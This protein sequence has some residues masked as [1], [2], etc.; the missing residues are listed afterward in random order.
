[1]V[2]WDAMKAEMQ[3][4][5]DLAPIAVKKYRNGPQDELER[6]WKLDRKGFIREVIRRESAGE[7][8]ERA[9]CR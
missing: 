3:N 8:Q 6:R 1:M 2:G 7:N 9:R 5:A 4:K